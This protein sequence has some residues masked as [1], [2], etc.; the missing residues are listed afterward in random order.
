[1]HFCQSERELRRV[2]D[3][4]LVWHFIDCSLY[5]F[6]SVYAMSTSPPAFS[7]ALPDMKLSISLSRSSPVAGAR[8]PPRAP[9]AAPRPRGAPLPLGAPR[10]DGPDGAPRPRCAGAPNGL[11]CIRERREAPGAEPF[12]AAPRGAGRGVCGGR[13]RIAIVWPG[14]QRLFCH[15]RKE[16]GQLTLGHCAVELVDGDFGL[17]WGGKLHGCFTFRSA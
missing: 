10:P 7:P 13:S 14:R 1:M 8:L 16:A 4:M 12:A 3:H 11:P 17:L 6:A 5:L 9:P 15:G 2:V